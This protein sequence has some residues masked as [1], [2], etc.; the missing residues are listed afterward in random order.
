MMH[1]APICT[2]WPM[3]PVFMI[4]LSSPMR[5]QP[6]PLGVPSEMV[7]C[8]RITVSEPITSS[9][10]P[11]SKLLSWGSPPSA[12]NGKM[13]VR[14]PTCVRPERCAWA[15]TSTPGPSE[16]S[17]PITAY[18]PMRT[19]FASSAP[20]STIAVGWT[21]GSG[22]TLLVEA[23]HHLVRDVER[24]ARVHHVR[25]VALQ[26]QREALLLADCLDDHPQLRLERRQHLALLDLELAL[27]LVDLALD[28]VLELSQLH[29]LLEQRIVGEHVFLALQLLGER[30][31]LVH[32]G[33]DLGARLAPLARDL[34]ARRLA[35]LRGGERLL[36][37]HDPDLDVLGARR[38]DPSHSHRQGENERR[39]PLALH[40]HLLSA[41]GAQKPW[42][43]TENSNAM[44]SSTESLLIGKPMKAWSGPKG[45][46]HSTPTPVPCR[47]ALKSKMLWSSAK[48]FPVSRKT[49]P[50]RPKLSAIGKRYSA[51]S[52]M[53]LLPPITSVSSRSANWLI[54]R[55]LMLLHFP[56]PLPSKPLNS[57][58]SRHSPVNHW[59]PT[60]VNSVPPLLVPLGGTTIGAWSTERRGPTERAWKPRSWKAPMPPRK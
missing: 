14:A 54:S 12:V 43:P 4:R 9:V 26:D 7:T 52:E 20:G 48:A 44:E 58:V 13:R 49:M 3:W 1:C 59:R 42:P 53:N 16:T 57:L 30:V 41:A 47:H 24:L 10:L 32:H 18:G 23:R 40:A 51:V 39:H 31:A 29:L 36:D 46:N 33:L 22:S 8:S 5:V 28:L 11:P 6:P 56:L 34:L 2:S 37:V 60:G 15:W 55:S 19:S 35:L 21:I 45:E 25:V 17:P 38:R 27:E 50:I